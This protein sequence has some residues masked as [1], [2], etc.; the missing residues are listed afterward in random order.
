[1]WSPS[2]KRWFCIDLKGCNPPGGE[3]TPQDDGP[4]DEPD[5]PAS[6]EDDIED[7]TQEEPEEEE[8]E[9]TGGEG[10]G[11]EGEED[12]DSTEE[13]GGG[14]DGEDDEGEGGQ[15]EDDE[16]IRPDPITQPAPPYEVVVKELVDKGY[17]QADAER[18]ATLATSWGGFQ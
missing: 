3:R 17:T 16:S 8:S 18:L 1:M 5:S 6:E 9:D 11:E 13:D 15:G 7:E 2:A 12:E 4:P 14:G 10:E